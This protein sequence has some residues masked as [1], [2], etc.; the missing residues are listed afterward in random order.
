MVPEQRQAGW[1]I[2]KALEEVV[3]LNEDHEFSYS[4]DALVEMLDEQLAPAEEE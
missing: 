2:G 4:R 1:T 3:S